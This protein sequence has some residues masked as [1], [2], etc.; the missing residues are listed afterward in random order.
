MNML[1]R[2]YNYILYYKK[3]FMTSA[4][5]RVDITWEKSPWIVDNQTITNPFHRAISEVMK[6]RSS[7]EY[8][9]PHSLANI[10]ELL[11]SETMKDQVKQAISR[12]AKSFL[13]RTRVL[14]EKKAKN[15]NGVHQSIKTVAECI[16]ILADDH[17]TTVSAIENAS[18]E[19]L[20][21]AIMYLYP[22][23]REIGISNTSWTSVNKNDDRLGY[24]N[25]NN[26]QWW[27]F[28]LSTK[29]QD[30]NATEDLS[31]PVKTTIKLS[32]RKQITDAD[33]KF[34][35]EQLSIKV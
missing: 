7:K 32:L 23:L 3:I 31:K 2:T 16:R 35:L 13:N 30:W 27:G 14:Q 9:Y 21:N 11:S 20:Q 5:L 33:R 26:G 25:E 17:V 10:R 22:E 12:M 34:A 28:Y 18:F 1:Y 4:T 24:K 15:P 8:S 19:E 6:D 29:S